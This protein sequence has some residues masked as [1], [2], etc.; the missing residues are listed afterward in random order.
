MKLNGI[1]ISERLLEGA[2][3]NM[4][5]VGPYPYYLKQRILGDKGHLSNERA[6][7]LLTRLIHDDLQAVLLGHLRSLLIRITS[8]P[9]RNLARRVKFTRGRLHERLHS[10]CGRRSSSREILPRNDK[11]SGRKHSEGWRHKGGCHG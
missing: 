7:Q 8:S 2:L 5:Q 3:I 10:I 11:H 6:G 4:L 9:R 1:K